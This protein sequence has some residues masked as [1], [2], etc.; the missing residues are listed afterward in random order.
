MNS[1]RSYLIAVLFS[2][3]LGGIGLSLVVK[4]TA[5]R[6]GE[7]QSIVTQSAVAATSFAALKI[8]LDV[9]ITISDLV[10][11]SDVSYLASPL[12]DQI[13]TLEESLATFRFHYQNQYDDAE[14]QLLT[15]ELGGLGRLLS[16][17]ISGG[18][19]NTDVESMR[20]YDECVAVLISAYAGSATALKRQQV[21]K[22]VELRQVETNN[23]LL[24]GGSSVLF[25]LMSLFI[26]N[27]TLRLVS[28]PIISLSAIE[29]AEDIDSSEVLHGR[30]IPAEVKGLT[31]H[32]LRLLRNL[33]E[34]VFERTQ[35]LKQRTEQ[36]ESQAMVLV[37]AKE[38]AEKA[39]TAKSVFLANMSHEIRTP[40]NAVI[41][42]SDLLVEQNLDEQQIELVEAISGSGRHLL[43]LIT[44]ILDFSRIEHG[45]VV[46]K[47]V[48]VDLRLHIAECVTLACSAYGQS[49]DHVQLDIAD[50][51]PN[52]IAIDPLSLKQILVNLLS[53]ALKFTEDGSITLRCVLK[54][55]GDAERLS[56]TIEDEGI[57]IKEED[58]KTIF[59]A[60]EQVDS[61]LSRGFEGAGLG[62]SISK[63]ISEAMG[64]SLAV[65]SEFGVGSTF[66]LEIP[67]ARVWSTKEKASPDD[68]TEMDL[69][70]LIVDDNNI[71]VILLKHILETK[72]FSSSVATNGQEAVDQV[73]VREFDIVLMD[74]QMPVMDGYEAI[75]CIRENEKITQPRIVV[76]T[77]FIEDENREMAMSAG[78]DAF[79]SKPINQDELFYSMYG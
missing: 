59:D 56:I 36:L 9:L 15:D 49:N 51:V 6:L 14:V 8:Q 29:S 10:F 25:I 70:V 61:A 27:R 1:I 54:A 63:R 7:K 17:K 3:F 62:L 48:E 39:N 22:V 46:Q 44:D 2:A 66:T 71:N 72:G 37:E 13:G 68:D 11:G 57:G 74:L 53:N 55:S 69:N 23:S 76:V 31:E 5:D 40:L 16:A 32:L 45:E 64:G 30:G 24:S 41:G 4:F 47:L 73:S 38:A 34:T 79:V 43:E 19:K 65:V 50:S 20:I 26:L 42:I 52:T 21:Q 35:S 12:R 58:C 77:A 18:V 78:A 33:E 60:F 67:F 28:T 75:K